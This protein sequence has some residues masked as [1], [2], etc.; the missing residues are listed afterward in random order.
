MRAGIS[1][2]IYQRIPPE[3]ALQYDNNELYPVCF[4][5]EM[6]QFMQKN[7]PQFILR[8]HSIRHKNNLP[9]IAVFQYRLYISV[10][11]HRCFK[12][13]PILFLNFFQDLQVSLITDTRQ[14]SKPM[15]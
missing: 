7:I 4:I 3:N 6:L 13:I 2:R 1:E 10:H 11:N 8:I 12:L 14:M 15:D 9:E 5:C